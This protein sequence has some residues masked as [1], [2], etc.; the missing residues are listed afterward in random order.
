MST[1][2]PI[3]SSFMI[4]SSSQWGHPFH[5]NQHSCQSHEMW[6]LTPLLCSVFVKS[7]MKG[8]F[9]IA[10]YGQNDMYLTA[11]IWTS[12]VPLQLSRLYLLRKIEWS[13]AAQQL[14]NDP[15]GESV[16]YCFQGQGGTLAFNLNAFIIF[17]ICSFKFSRWWDFDTLHVQYMF[18]SVVSLNLI[19]FYLK[20]E[21][22][23][24]K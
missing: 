20:L 22:V 13:K 23:E 16:L 3:A 9:E 24:K 18:N 15:F 12:T 14:L 2:D 8:H 21:N 6:C 11:L 1:V 17:F 4:T 19:N 5:F 7:G 10:P